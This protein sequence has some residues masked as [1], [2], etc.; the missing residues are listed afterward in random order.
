MLDENRGSIVQP[1]A[2]DP[3]WTT[4]DQREIEYF[5]LH[6]LPHLMEA[7]GLLVQMFVAAAPISGIYINALVSFCAA[8]FIS[9]INT[10][11]S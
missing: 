5:R 7:L 11:V 4:I 6:V 8:N 1:N 2:S 10:A 3:A 9:E